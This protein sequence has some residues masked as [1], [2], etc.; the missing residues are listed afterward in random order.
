MRTAHQATSIVIAAA[1]TLSVAACGGNDTKPGALPTKGIASASPTATIKPTPSA[2]RNSVTPTADN[3]LGIDWVKQSKQPFTGAAADKFGAAN[4]MAAYR[5]AVTFSLRE[6]YS[7]LM[8]KGYDARP[9]EFSFIK[10]YLTT[11]LQNQW[12]KDVKA[13]LAKDEDA[14]GNVYAV[15]TWNTA[16]GQD[17][18]KF[19]KGQVLFTLGRTFSPA[20][21]SVQ[22]IGA[23][24]Y[25][26]IQFTV[27]RNIR[28]MKAGKAV[29]LPLEKDI[30]YR[31][32]P[33]GLKDMPWLIDAW[34]I[35]PK[36]GD[37]TPDPLGTAS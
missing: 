17:V 25:L 22:T 3:P 8:A 34:T 36:V 33:N 24:D 31:M 1:L 16:E 29:L 12:D 18:Y 27:S 11:A 13:A 4:V 21:A 10:P 26:D 2:T 37:P 30:T 28:F 7:N 35:V 14:V 9:V 15:T 32:T 6:G 20:T 5:H 23:K 19:R